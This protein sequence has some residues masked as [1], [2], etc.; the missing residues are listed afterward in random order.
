MEFKK[1]A[2]I[3]FFEETSRQDQKSSKSK[4]T[5][6]VRK[7]SF[8]LIKN[9]TE[10]GAVVLLLLVVLGLA[11][12]YF[13]ENTETRVPTTHFEILPQESVG[14]SQGLPPNRI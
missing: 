12:Y 6:F 3:Q 7:I 11:T 4:L 5:L 8:G 10:A 9:D 2:E 13:I 1:P 14:S